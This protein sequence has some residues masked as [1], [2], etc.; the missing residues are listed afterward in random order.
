M[1][2]LVGG[3][4]RRSGDGE[5]NGSREVVAAVSRAV[6][7]GLELQALARAA[8]ERLERAIREETGRV[9]K[10]RPWAVKW[11]RAVLLG[12]PRRAAE[13]RLAAEARDEAEAVLQAA[14]ERQE[15]VGRAALDR[16]ETLGREVRRASARAREFVS[17]SEACALR[18]WRWL[19]MLRRW[20]WRA[21]DSPLGADGLVPEPAGEARTR[22][23]R[24][25]HNVP[26]GTV[27]ARRNGIRVG[28]SA[29]HENLDERAVHP[30]RW[31]RAGGGRS[32][33]RWLRRREVD[34]GREADRLGRWRVARLLQVERPAHRRGQQLDVQ[35]ECGQG[36]IR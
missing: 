6:R 36:S 31:W 33:L 24:A 27:W 2:R 10:A 1:R 19:A 5:T 14:E 30:L 34:E 7:A 26:T 17:I 35:V 13:L 3:A 29:N 28:Y 11:R 25:A 22:C 20:R 12:G 9:R 18:E 16:W 21:A 4:V 8:T 23:L 32:A 15:V